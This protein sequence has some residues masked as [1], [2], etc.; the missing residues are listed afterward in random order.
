MNIGTSGKRWPFTV[1]HMP[2][3]PS[4]NPKRLPMSYRKSRLAFEG[5]KPRGADF[6]YERKSTVSAGSGTG[7]TPVA[8]TAAPPPASTRPGPSSRRST[9]PPAVTRTARFRSGAGSVTSCP[10]IAVTRNV[11]PLTQIRTG[12]AS[13]L[14]TRSRFA[15]SA[16]TPGVPLIVRLPW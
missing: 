1:H 10:S 5:S 15:V 4:R 14:T 9:R 7:F 3:L 6:P 16:A 2:G 8:A 13:V 12:P 11:V